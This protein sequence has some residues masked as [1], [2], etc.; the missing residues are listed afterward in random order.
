MQELMVESMA[1]AIGD[2]M[3]AYFRELLGSVTIYLCEENYKSGN[4]NTVRESMSETV[5]EIM[6]ETAGKLWQTQ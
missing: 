1:A 3:R 4:E 6:T 2:A 5:A